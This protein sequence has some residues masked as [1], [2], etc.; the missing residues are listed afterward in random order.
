MCPTT[1]RETPPS[2]DF[3]ATARVRYDPQTNTYHARHE[4]ETGDPLHVTVVESVAVVT[5]T[6]LTEIQALYSTID[7][8]A[9]D[10]VVDPNRRADV[11]IEFQFEGCLVRIESSGEITIEIDGDR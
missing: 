7:P 6:E 1:T 5:E 2:T 4:W 11:Q 3:D 9:L 8:E 10:A